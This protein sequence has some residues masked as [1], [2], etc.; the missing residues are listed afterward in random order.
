MALRV[1]SNSFESNTGLTIP[2][3]QVLLVRRQE[4]PRPA[5]I[6]FLPARQM[7]T[8]SRLVYLTTAKPGTCT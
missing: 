8:S 1:S 2:R 4:I 5:R 3:D 7:C 6:S